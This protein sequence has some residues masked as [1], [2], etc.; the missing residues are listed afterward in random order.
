MTVSPPW[1]GI[2]RVAEPTKLVTLRG[3]PATALFPGDSQ[4]AALMRDKD[5]AATSLGP[6]HTW[7]QALKSAVRI[8]LTSRFSMWLGW[9]D[10]L[11]FL[12]NDSYRDDTLGPKHPAALGSPASQVWREIWPEIGPRI[13]AVL[14]GAATWDQGLLLF[15]ERFGFPE[16]TYHTFSYSPLHDDDGTI[17][18]L[19]CV[20][21]EDT[22]RMISERRVALLGR[23]SSEIANTNTRAGVLAAL[24]N[25]L[26]QDA[27]DLPFTLT[28]LL[29][30]DGHTLRL[31][32]QTSFATDSPLAPPVLDVDAGS[33]WPLREVLDEGKPLE[34]ALP[35]A[36]WPTGPWAVRPSLAFAVPLARQGHTRAAGVLI[37][38]I[39]P[40]RRFDGPFREL[41]LL[42][43]GQVAS[44][45][46]NADAYAEERRRAEV[47]AELDAAKTAFFSNVSHEFRT[48]L[49]LMLGPLG[50]LLENEAAAPVH[51]E[52]AIIH[53]N[54]LRLLRLVN[55]MLDFSRIEAGRATA[56]FE[57]VDLSQLTADLA[58]VF[59]AAVEKAGLALRVEC[60]P[61]GTLV[62]VDRDMW[63]KI[64]L[65]LVSNAFKFTLA[66]EIRVRLERRGGRV[67]LSVCDT[68]T[69]I[70][71][72]ELPRVFE[73][74][75]R[76][77]GTKGRTHEGTGIGLALVQELARLHGGTVDITS[78]VGQGSEFTV[79]IPIGEQVSS[80]ALA[81][82]AREVRDRDAF[83]EEAM[84][85]LPDPPAPEPVAPGKRQRLVVADDNADMRDYMRR[86]LGVR[87]DVETV[88]N[89]R[90]ALA[91]ISRRTAD[92]LVTDI[93]MPE[94]DGFGLVAAIRADPALHDLPVIMLSARAG[95]EARIEGLQSGA[96]DYLVKPFAA[97][98]LI[99]HVE[100]QLL[101]AAMRAAEQANARRYARIFEH[102]PVSIA[103]LRGPTH[104]FEIANSYYR[105]LVGGREV[106][107]LSVAEALPEVVA[108]GFIALLDRVYQTAEP[109][110]GRSTPVTLRRGPEGD[111]EDV[112][113][114][115]IYQPMLD[116]AGAVI[117]IAVI[118]HEVTAL[119]LAQRQAETANRAKDEFLAMLGHELRNPLAPISTALQLMR[120]KSNV[121]AERERAVIERQ[122]QHLIGL[123]DD[124]LDVSRITRGKVELR[125]APVS[126]ADALARSIEVAS[127]V[128]E[129]QRHTLDVDV[130][131]DLFV[132]ADLGRL[133]QIISNLLTNAAKYTPPGGR[134]T[135]RGRRAGDRVELSVADNG[136]GIDPSMLELIFEPFIQ[137]RQ[138]LERSQGGLGLGLA[139]VTNL[140]KLHGGTVRARSDGRGTGSEF[141]MSLPGLAMP[142]PVEVAAAQVSPGRRTGRGRVLVVDDNV[143]AAEMLRDLLVSAGYEVA[144]AHDGVEALKIVETFRPQLGVFDLGLPVMDGFELA[145]SIQ[146]RTDLAAPKLVALTGYG[147]SEDRAKTAAAGF[148]AHL[149]KPVDFEKLR[150][151]IDRLLA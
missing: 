14:A 116:D 104:V 50:S 119:A 85:W 109:Y 105:M 59:R 43:A 111:A 101:R 33:P 142:A 144:I 128:F 115:F 77:E 139:I 72:A 117:G 16:E 100:A 64:V 126:L 68:G 17:R 83:V 80:V 12:Y 79:T 87:W 52:L 146:G 54:A 92:L 74:F 31:A 20:V 37:A 133:S 106:V 19:L 122:V 141:V 66:G 148:A 99:A 25:S 29:D 78:T 61:L 51:D 102:A 8:V 4:L 41:V 96:N 127:P 13:A 42:F 60:P 56:Q 73:R 40:H 132:T 6:T 150:A 93:M 9:G 49:T 23:L 32:S 145:R 58:S 137:T 47:L 121:G 91:A 27:R 114:D 71:A 82:P 151:M 81:A 107:G 90:E 22:G 21:S 143:D 103:I 26:A 112:F 130:P 89:G 3:M 136:I 110:V 94:L 86:I 38:G 10:E 2:A 1:R 35:D 70:P 57:P 45:L 134:V 55:T 48:P 98:E 131:R 24:E 63:E 34:I 53:R 11:A 97:R 113:V 65:N 7:P 36:A 5:W 44:G 124:L 15:L 129:Q 123:V 125:V 18:G 118:A 147:Q 75:H 69:G 135:V 149:V 138:S 76:V 28:Y 30:E 84:R 88:A 62:Q 39:N 95:E 140:V 46:A 108:Q 120:L 67:A